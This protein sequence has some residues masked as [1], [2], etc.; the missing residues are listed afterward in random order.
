ML[1]NNPLK[2]YFRQPAIY[3][4]LPSQGQYYPDGT[5]NM[6][7]NGEIPVY[8]MTAI[9]EITYRTPDAL[10]NGGATVSVIKSCVPN[11]LEPWAIPA[12]D[13]DTILV[14]I[15]IASYGHSM[16]LESQCP[17]CQHQDNFGVDLRTVL[18]AM[19]TPDY[20]KS[21]HYRDIEIYFRPM[22]YQMINE[23]N[24][25]QFE[26]QRLL[27]GIN[28][29]EQDDAEKLNQLTQAL[30]KI[31]AI[32]IEALGKSIAAIKTPN[33]LVTEQEYIDDFI[34]NCDRALF[35]QIRDYIVAQKTMSEL[36]PLTIK[37]PECSKDYQQA[38]TLDMSNF[39]SPAS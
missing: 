2:Q 26:E 31:T 19:K 11:I 7:P 1:E 29:S 5:L 20:Q 18:D 35:T 37:C 25:K 36:Q 6:P 12:M 30:A 14:S 39:F 28:L 9:D 15:R 27:Q 32:T 34:K 22:T 3:I 33:A 17:H 21:I 23:N 13:L 4:R 8:P 24:K 16:D 38:I 10:F